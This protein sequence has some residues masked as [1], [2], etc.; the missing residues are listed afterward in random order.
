MGS[1]VENLNFVTFSEVEGVNI[2]VYDYISY[3]TSYLI[4]ENDNAT[5]IIYLLVV[6]NNH[7]NTLRVKGQTKRTDFQKVKKKD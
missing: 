7:V 6:N 4:A 5:H 2:I 1:R 3:S